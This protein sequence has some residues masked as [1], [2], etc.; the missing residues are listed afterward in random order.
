[1][2]KP[3]KFCVPI[4][5]VLMCLLLLPSACSKKVEQGGRMIRF[6]D[7]FDSSNLVKSPLENLRDNFEFGEEDL[8]SR[9]QEMVELS[10]QEVRIWAAA[11]DHKILG[12]DE[13]KLPQGMSLVHDGRELSFHPYGRAGETTWKWKRGELVLPA[14]ELKNYKR[15]LKCS[16][17]NSQKPVEFEHVFPRGTVEF[18]VYVKKAQ[19]RT[20]DSRLELFLDGRRFHSVEVRSAEYERISFKVEVDAKHYAA[21]LATSKGVLH[22]KKI[23]INAAHDL[24]LLSQ[25]QNDLLHPNQGRSL[26]RYPAQKIKASSTSLYSEE[27]LVS[28]LKEEVI[29]SIPDLGVTPDLL[30]IKKKLVFEDV[31]LNSLLAPPESEF[32]FEIDI[33]ADAVLEFGYGIMENTWEADSGPVDFEIILM[34]SGNPQPIFA[35]SLFPAENDEHRR[36]RFE[37]IDISGYAGEKVGLQLITRFPDPQ[38]QVSAGPA[39]LA[40]WHNPT[41]FSKK[42]AAEDRGKDEFNVILISLDTLRW[43]RLGCYGYERE[44]SPTIDTLAEDCVRFSYCFA[45]SN[46]TLPSHVST[47]TALH[48]RRHQVY[49]DHEKM[50]SS[51][52]TIADILRM[53]GFYTGGITGGG[54]V[55]EKFGFSKGFDE[56]KGERYVFHAENEAEELGLETVDWLGRNADKRFFLFLHTYQ[57]HDPYYNHPGITDAFVEGEVSWQSMPIASF[58]RNQDEKR[59]YEFTQKEQQDIVALYDGEISYTDKFLIAPVL[60]KLKDLGLYENTLIVLTSDHGEEFLDH[61][62]WLHA[63]TL[64]NELI[65]VPL[66]IKYPGSKYKGKKID[67]VIRSIDIVPTI[68]EAAGIESSP[69]DM[70]GVSLQ[71]LVDGK[72]ERNRIFFSDFSHK[73]S[74]DLRPTMVCTN[75][76]FLKLILNRKPSPPRNFLFDMLDD[77]HES[78]NLENTEPARL[79]EMFQSILEYYDN[80]KE[81]SLKSDQVLMDKALEERLKALGYIR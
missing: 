71:R 29:T 47:L 21:R 25:S 79:R 67:S 41:V 2:K 38:E 30:H 73:G 18:V 80:F 48:G 77:V 62:S 20:P 6:I 33:P 24:I 15:K 17:I 57:I 53:Q 75:R 43:D 64:Y 19:L 16:V 63:H 22:V 69:F 76:D 52:I 65:R 1:M 59:K 54:Y 8:S 9:W 31:A 13:S 4:L 81:I 23:V 35:G 27:Y 42:P 28:L 58:L 26:L 55:S 45:Q 46:W 3:R 70:D 37:K 72:E 32:R 44:T 74:S 66:L 5:L 12:Y 78:R 34:D 56:Y 14:I 60:K 51:L 36:V 68:L 7:T 10:D 11:A 40:F 61:G 50:S 39:P 49:L